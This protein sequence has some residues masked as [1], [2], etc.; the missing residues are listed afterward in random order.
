MK[1]LLRNAVIPLLALVVIAG[2]VGFR[3]MFTPMVIETGS[4]E[5]VMPPGTIAF[6]QPTT[7]LKPGDI[8][9]FQQS[10]M[11]RP[12]THTFIGYAKD[13]SLRTKGD[14][15]SFPDV[16]PDGPLH[17]SQVVGKVMF[18]LPFFT[19]SYWTSVRGILSIGVVILTILAIII[20]VMRSRK[21]GLQKEKT[22]SSALTSNPV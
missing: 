5:P 20:Y 21:K 10:T 9:S 14:A 15:N 11:K 17:K 18:T 2:I 6:I 8:I 19:G 7:S 13:G 4:M 3:L 16:H 22:V 1:K 12:T